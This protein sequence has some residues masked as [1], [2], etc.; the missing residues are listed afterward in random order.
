[1]T[2]PPSLRI[3]RNL[4]HIYVS[5]RRRAQK[6]LE[7][8]QVGCR[9]K[10]PL[11]TTARTPRLTNPHLGQSRNHPDI[12][13]WDYGS[14]EGITSAEIRAQ[15]ATASL[16]TWDIWRDGCPDGESPE[17]VT[18]RVDRLIADIRTKYHAPVIGKAKRE[19]PPGDVLIVA[20][21]HILRAFAM[22]WWGRR[23]RMDRRFLLEAGGVGTL[24]Y[25]HKNLEEPAI[26][27]GGAFMVDV[28]E[29]SARDEKGDVIGEGGGGY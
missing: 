7:L 29:N 18:E 2:T 8:L 16:P 19:A 1:M 13:E 21:G 10:A 5:P 15:R 17:Q 6:T 22:R 11:G 20:H 3:P 24:S 23:C 14:Y 27:L 9:E 12:R 26:L 28:V 25:E 4:A